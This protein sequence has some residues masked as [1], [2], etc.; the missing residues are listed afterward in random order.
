MPLGTGC[1][2]GSCLLQAFSVTVRQCSLPR[3]TQSNSARRAISRRTPIRFAPVAVIE[4]WGVDLTTVDYDLNS[5][6]SVDDYQVRSSTVISVAT[7][8]PDFSSLVDELYVRLHSLTRPI[9]RRSSSG[10]PIV[11]TVDLMWE[12]AFYESLDWWNDHELVKLSHEARRCLV[13]EILKRDP[14]DA[15][16]LAIAAFTPDRLWPLQRS[17]VEQM[18]SW[19]GAL[20]TKHR[21]I[22]HAL[23]LR[24]LAP[25]FD[26]ESTDFNVR[27][28]RHWVSA[29]CVELV[30]AALVVSLGLLQLSPARHANTIL[31]LLLDLQKHADFDQ[32]G[33]EVALGWL[34]GRLWPVA[35]NQVEH[36][37]QENCQVTSRRVFRHA[38]ARIPSQKRQILTN[39]WKTRRKNR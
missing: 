23:A 14:M 4:R 37:L 16:L 5:R 30:S 21:A 28:L 26:G 24:V 15:V 3:Q 18:K 22:G 11:A 29:G 2:A 13:D 35:P 36:W 8:L 12:S 20:D 34:L 38:V 6:D 1:L 7:A 9:A 19:Y 17:H 10:Y 39:D 25:W 33:G 31:Q 32:I 27:E